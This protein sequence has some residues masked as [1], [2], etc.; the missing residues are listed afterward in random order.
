MSKEDIK[1]L[2]GAPVSRAC[3]VDLQFG[4]FCGDMAGR[5]LADFVAKV[6]AETE[7][8]RNLIVQHFL[9][10]KQY[11]YLFFLDTDEWPK[12]KDVLDKLLAMDK[13]IAAGVTK[14]ILDGRRCWSAARFV[15]ENG[16]IHWAGPKEL[17]PGPFKAVAVGGSTMLIKRCVFEAIEWPWFEVVYAA[18]GSRVGEDINFCNKVLTAGFEIWVDPRLQCGHRQRRDISE[19]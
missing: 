4:L 13:D 1:I 19:L 2:I 8:A 17:P 7:H 12:D 16:L 14:M 15:N 3:M 18:D 6:A 10:R 5:G 11:E 9:D